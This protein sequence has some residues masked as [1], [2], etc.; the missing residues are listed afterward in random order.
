[1]TVLDGTTTDPYA[2]NRGLLALDFAIRAI[3]EASVYSMLVI[4]LTRV[5][6]K[7]QPS[8]RVVVQER[9]KD[10]W[11]DYLE[12]VGRYDPRTNPPTVVLNEE[13]I[14]H[15][16]GKGAQPSD[17]MWN[18]LVDAKVVDGPKRRLVRISRAKQ[19]KEAAAKAKEAAPAAA[20]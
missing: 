19:A 1:M 11:G 15:W 8:Y 12:L 18:L 20:A 14:R 17:T 10:P 6:K 2:P 3:R 13:R 16:I 4:R 5:G 9:S 7:Q